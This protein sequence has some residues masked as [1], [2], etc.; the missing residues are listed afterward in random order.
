MD[1][2]A[3]F[4]FVGLV[5]I[6]STISIIDFNYHKKV[7]ICASK[8]KSGSHTWV[9]EGPF[10]PTVHTQVGTIS[11]PMLPAGSSKSLFLFPGPL[12]GCTAALSPMAL[13]PSHGW[14]QRPAGALTAVTWSCCSISRAAP[15]LTNTQPSARFPRWALQQFTENWGNSL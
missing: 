6:I 14:H 9:K 11:P 3:S 10:H 15:L 1:F 12:C 8:W 5:S 4:L 7:K 13:P 2:C